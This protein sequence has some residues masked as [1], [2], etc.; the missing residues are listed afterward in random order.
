MNSK[1]ITLLLA[2]IAA[3]LAAN[4]IVNLPLQEAKAQTHLK[5]PQ[6]VDVA[7]AMPSGHVT[8]VRILS[9]GF[10]E[11]KVTV[12]DPLGFGPLVWT[13]LPANPDAPQSRPIAACT[14]GG[15]P[16]TVIYR[17]WADGTVDHIRFTSV[18]TTV[19]T[20]VEGWITEPN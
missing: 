1:P 16:T 5:A 14:G 12:D 7:I 10:A 2:I 4:L 20:A 11:Y 13:P 17:L 8:L 19:T 18:E 6:F 15:G 3:L 9:D